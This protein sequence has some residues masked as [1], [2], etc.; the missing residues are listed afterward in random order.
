MRGDSGF[1]GTKR[2]NRGFVSLLGFSSDCFSISFGLL[3]DRTVFQCFWIDYL[4]IHNAVPGEIFL[5]SDRINV[6]QTILL[7]F[8]IE[9]V[10][11]DQPVQSVGG[12]RPRNLTLN[13]IHHDRERR[14]IAAEFSPQPVC[15]LFGRMPFL[16]EARHG[17]LAFDMPVPFPEST[18][19]I[20]LGD[21]PVGRTIT[22]GQ[23]FRL[24]GRIVHPGLRKRHFSA[25]KSALHFCK[26]LLFLRSQVGPLLHH[27]P[28]VAF[29]RMPAQGVFL[30]GLPAAELHPA[31]VIVNEPAGT[32]QE[33]MAVTA[34]T[35][36]ITQENPSVNGSRVLRIQRSDPQFSAF[37]A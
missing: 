23:G 8:G 32:I 30:I 36:F 37:K 19:D 1:A 33:G 14:Q 4:A 31:A 20:H 2:R 10:I 17:V 26:A 29:D 34:D 9:L 18:L 15:D 16:H 13:V 21:N 11:P 3:N 24:D 27:V 28:D 25:E 6:I 5:D 12:I 7:F 35:V 22:L